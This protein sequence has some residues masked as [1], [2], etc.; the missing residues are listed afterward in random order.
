[1]TAHEVRQLVAAIEHGPGGALR[2]RAVEQSLDA[3]PENAVALQ[4]VQRHVTPAFEENMPQPS[5][6]AAI[7]LRQLIGPKVGGKEPHAAADIVSDRLRNDE[8]IGK[9]DRSDRNP[10]AS[11]KIWRQNDSFDPGAD[12]PEKAGRIQIF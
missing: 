8:A 5:V 4:R 1:M 6:E 9:K 12:I 11:M 10:G 3:V 7:E 2:A